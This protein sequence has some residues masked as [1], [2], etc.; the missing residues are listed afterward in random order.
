MSLLALSLVGYFAFGTGSSAVVITGAGGFFADIEKITANGAFIYPA[1]AQTAS[2]EST[3]STTDGRP[4]NGD[5]AL[6][7]LRVDLAGAT[8]PSGNSIE[9]IKTVN[10]PIIPSIDN[11]S[12]VVRQDGVP[13]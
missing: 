1:M 11:F 7:L 10:T 13:G 5:T 8:I 12:V 6:P 3:I 4:E 2:C 9:L